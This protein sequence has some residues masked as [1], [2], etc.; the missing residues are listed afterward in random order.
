M[1]LQHALSNF[2]LDLV[3]T[4][5]WTLAP[6]IF[7]GVAANG[8]HATGILGQ[9]DVCVGVAVYRGTEAGAIVWSR[10]ETMGVPHPSD[11]NR[12]PDVVKAPMPKPPPP[13]FR[14]SPPHDAQTVIEYF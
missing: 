7:V 6:S 10:M 5:R 14:A 1:E 3:Y 4:P 11:G 13:V 8:Q 9:P 2:S 12:P